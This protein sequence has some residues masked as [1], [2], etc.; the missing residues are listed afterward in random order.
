VRVVVV[1]Q[2]NRQ[3]SDVGCVLFSTCREK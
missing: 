2:M 1:T 3:Y